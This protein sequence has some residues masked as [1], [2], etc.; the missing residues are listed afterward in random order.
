MK[1]MRWIEQI[2]VRSSASALQEAMP[3]LLKRV[4]VIEE[5][6][7]DA[8]TYFMQHALYDGDLAVVLVWINDVKPQKTREGMMVAEQLQG[9]GPI[10]HAVWIPAESVVGVKQKPATCNIQKYS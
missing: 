8:E 3:D 4:K 6:A 2:R 5:G 7:C 10:D 9:L 1:Q